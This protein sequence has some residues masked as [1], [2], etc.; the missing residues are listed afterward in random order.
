MGVTNQANGNQ[1][2][3]TVDDGF[4]VVAPRTPGA[5]WNQIFIENLHGAVLLQEFVNQQ[6]GLLQFLS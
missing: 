4:G 5:E 3:H 2:T 6:R 1:A